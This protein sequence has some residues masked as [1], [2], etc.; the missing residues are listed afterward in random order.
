[1]ITL[2]AAEQLDWRNSQPGYA[3]LVVVGLLVVASAL[4]A[5]SF[6]R[7]VRKAKEPWDDEK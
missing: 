3:A 1:M 2:L 5:R 4:L 6:L 7:H